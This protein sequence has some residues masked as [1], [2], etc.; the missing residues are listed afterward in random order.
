MRGAIWVIED[1]RRLRETVCEALTA[2]TADRVTGFH[3]CEAAVSAA[4]AGER[5][6]VILLDLALP[7]MSGHEGLRALKQLVP[8]AQI[9][10]FT[11]S[12]DRSHVYEAV[13][14]GASGYLLKSEPL[15]RIAS[16]VEEV[17]RGGAP[18]TAEI[19]RTILDRF[20]ALAGAG[21]G[22]PA[23]RTATAPKPATS[24]S[25]REREVLRLLAD[26]RTKKEIAADLGLSLHTVDN[27]VRRIYG[28]LHVNN[29]GGAVARAIRDG[30][31]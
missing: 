22:H 18:M 11:V 14:S 6:D 16:A 30:I 23:E 5:P 10:I 7:G 29:L 2:A 25:D 8:E 31:M 26:G 24:I 1:H 27:Y 4:T 3:N 9:I 19:A 21:G 20:S 17:R 13:C 12:D 15:E 28:K